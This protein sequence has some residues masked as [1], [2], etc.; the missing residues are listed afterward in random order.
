MEAQ[1]RIYTYCVVKIQKAFYSH[2]QTD[3]QGTQNTIKV[4]DSALR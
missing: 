1:Y 3:V 2:N 4:V